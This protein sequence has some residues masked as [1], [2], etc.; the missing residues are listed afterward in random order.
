MLRKRCKK[1]SCRKW[2]SDKQNF[3]KTSCYLPGMYRFILYSIVFLIAIKISA[4]PKTDKALQTIL[5]RN[6]NPVFQQVLQ[7][8]DTYRVQIIYTQID[9]DR[10]NR[11][12]FTNYYFHFDPL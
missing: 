9:R 12:H 8:P 4:Q 11:P 3:F 1:Y 6:T 2:N 5:A 10:H 7:H